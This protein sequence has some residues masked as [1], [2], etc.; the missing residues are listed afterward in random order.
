MGGYVEPGAARHRI[1][2]VDGIETLRI[3]PRRQWFVIA[4][5]PIWLTMWTFGGVQAMKQVVLDHEPFLVVWLIGWAAGW[6]Y[7]TTTLAMQV[8][9]SELV[10]VVHGDLEVSSGVG[11]LRRTWRYRGSAIG[12]LTSHVPTDSIWT[13]RGL[14]RPFFLT[15]TSGAVRFS[16][17]AKT[18]Y[19]APGIDE[20][21]GRQIVAWMMRRLP[22]RAATA[23][24]A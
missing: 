4:F 22:Q 6:I 11:P 15:P 10:H 16:Y 9:G 24:S 8:A 2:V 13:G 18:V 17:G 23:P 20:P 7:A 14:D 1:V 3:P 21:E 19:L 5:L 12:D